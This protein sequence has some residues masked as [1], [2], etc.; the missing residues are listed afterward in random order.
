MDILILTPRIPY[1][2]DDGGA[3]AIY[4]TIKELTE[5]GHIVTVLSLNTRKHFRRPDTIQ[6]ICQKVIAVDIDT[7]VRVLPA[8]EALFF[9]KLPYNIRR[10]LSETF[11][12]TLLDVL[13]NQ[14]FDV[15]QLEGVYLA[16]YLDLIKRQTKTPVVL[17][18]HN[19]EYEIWQKMARDEKNILKKWY[20]KRMSAQGKVFETDALPKFD[21]VVAITET[22]AVRFRGLGYQG[23]QVVI[24]VGVETAP[25]EVYS[26][27]S[28]KPD[29]ICFL[30]SLEWAPN[31]AGLWWFLR[32]VWPLIRQ[33]RP[34]AILYIAGKNPPPDLARLDLPNVCFY[35]YVPDARAFIA[36]YEVFIVP[37]L[38]GSG[39]RVKI[40]EAAAMQKCVITTEQGV[41]G[42]ALQNEE[43]ALITSEPEKFAK[44][45]VRALTDAPFREAIA[46]AAFRF[47][48]EQYDWKLLISHFTAFYTALKK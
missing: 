25:K 33:K 28:V 1:P 26:V 7:T 29:S 19:V 13:K 8:L 39:L 11:S 16:L 22:D 3:I 45:V 40:L 46:H 48:Q 5:A 35:G 18:A 27:D 42:L 17:R 9:S 32:N 36:S 44:Y 6:P 12:K 2:P 38:A 15:I 4:H 34:Q 20:F 43:E 14:K 24:P 41:E 37:L 30:A 10:F 31:V 23:P 21:G 47:V